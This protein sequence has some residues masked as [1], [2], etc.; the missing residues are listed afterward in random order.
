MDTFANLLPSPLAHV[1]PGILALAEQQQVWLDS[2]AAAQEPYIMLDALNSTLINKV[3]SDVHAAQHRPGERATRAFESARSSI[4]KWLQA[5][6][7]DTPDF[8]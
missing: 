7:Q 3:W 2:A 5:D 8:H 6:A 1:F 4:A